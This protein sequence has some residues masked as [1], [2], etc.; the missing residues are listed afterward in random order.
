MKSMV[1]TKKKN[2]LV[3]GA[4]RLGTTL[5]SVLSI[6]PVRDLKIRYIASRTEKSLTKA[7][8]IIGR[9]GKEIFFTKDID[10]GVKDCSIIFICT[11]DDEIEKVC[12]NIVKNA[13]MSLRGKYFIHFSGS[14]RLEVL[15]NAKKLGAYIASIHPM[16]SFASIE[17][18]I[19]TI[20]GTVYGITTEKMQLP[21]ESMK[22]KNLIT[23]IVES[24]DGTAVE[25]KDDDKPLYH[26]AACVA[27]NY[28]VSLV[29]Y[30]VEI[31][32]KIGIKSE[33]SLKGLIGLIE[34]TIDNIKKLGTKKSL[35]GPIARGDTGTIKEH[36]DNIKKNFEK[37]DYLLYKVLGLATSKIAYKNKWITRNTFEKFKKIFMDDM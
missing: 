20:G 36:L 8:K 11:P 31:N 9:Y 37:D 5:A 16:K 28:L 6:N 1:K 24:L 2:I 21:R 29:N 32:E 22:V 33:D 17:D 3:I 4:G 10:E 18:S 15:K 13:K 35:T 34:S 27:S 26:A 12:N 19:K 23:N 7:K 14:K 30:A 25:V